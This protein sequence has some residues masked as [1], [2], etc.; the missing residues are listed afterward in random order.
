MNTSAG[1]PFHLRGNYAPVFE[2]V[3]TDQLEVRGS[4]PIELDGRYFRN[5]ANPITGESAHWFLGD[6]MIHGVR[7][8][9]GRA[10]WYRNRW[11]KTPFYESP[12]K[13]VIDLE[14]LDFSSENSK[15]IPMSLLMRVASCVLKRGTSL[16]KYRMSWKQWGHIRLK[17]GL[18]VLSLRT[19]RFA[20]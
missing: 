16:G 9:E 11:V 1:A 18:M 7:L 8:R 5:G 15:P 20:L 13:P 12:T 19:P 4:I 14:N 6:G 17:V 2:E 3:T 10:D